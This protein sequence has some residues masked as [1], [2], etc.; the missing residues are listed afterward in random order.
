MSSVAAA[1]GGARYAYATLAFVMLFWAGNSIVGRAIRD[2]IPPFTLA[3]VRWVGASAVLLPLAWRQL[4]KDHEEM[5][6]HWKIMLALGVFGVAGF[7]GFLYSGLHYTSATNSLLLQAAIP[8]GVL[9]MDRVLFRQKSS[10][11]QILGVFLSALGVIVVVVQ[12]D[13]RLLANFRFSFGDVL[14]L[15]GVLVWSLYTSLLRLKPA[16]HQLSFLLVTFVI[17]ALCM[18]PLA[19]A[20]W[21]AAQRMEFDAELL[22]ACAY[23]AIFPSVLSYLLFN[24]AVER[25]GASRAGQTISLMPLFGAGLAAILLDEPL[26]GYHIAGMAFILGGIALGILTAPGGPAAA[27]DPAHR[28]RGGMD[29][30]HHV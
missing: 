17:A 5:L 3:L 2:D 20:E 23:V 1:R 13:V 22:A 6:R 18:A 29:S 24:M 10:A 11:G 28:R 9:L 16:V 4:V 27:N 7:N 15:G 8:G 25:I 12:A 21:N 14:V 19:L 30:S 26:H